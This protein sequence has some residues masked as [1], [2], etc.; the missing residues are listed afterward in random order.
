MSTDIKPACQYDL[1][2]PFH[3]QET[4]LDRLTAIQTFM[5]DRQFDREYLLQG[6]AIEHFESKI[7]ELFGKQAAM[8]CSTGTLAQGIAARIYA[9]K[10]PNQPLLLHCTSHLQLHE[11]DGYRHAH[12]LDARTIG[13][14]R[15]PVTAELL[16]EDTACAF[17]ELPQRHSGGLLPT[18]EQL[19]ALKQKASELQLP[20]H[21]DGARIWSCRPYYEN[22]SYAEIVSGFDS[23]YV[24]L[25]KDIGAIGGALLIGDNDFIKQAR[26]WRTRLGGLLVEPW[27]MVCD[28]LRL[29]DKR[30]AQ[31]PRFV[32][33]A[34]ELAALIA[35][36]DKIRIDPQPPQINLFHGLLPCSAAQAEAARDHAAI[37]TGVW[38]AKRFWNYEGNEQCAME[39]TIGEKACDIP[40]GKFADAVAALLDSI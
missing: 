34:G 40:D 32:A 26:I 15:E 2:F 16:D 27:P 8:W 12:G 1:S 35:P 11:E 10:R 22:S 19:T 36:M 37:K 28:A 18:W 3:H 6:P 9:D 13:K 5:T 31:M 21:M 17:I 25:Y 33:R 30:L 39:I 38:L 20:L 4:A 14:W 23:I 7:A 29:L 24:S